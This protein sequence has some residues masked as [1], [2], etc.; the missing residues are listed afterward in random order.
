MKI[1]IGGLENVILK[2]ATI[3]STLKCPTFSSMSF[4]IN[5]IVKISIEPASY[6]EVTKLSEALETLVLADPNLG[7][8]IE[9]SGLY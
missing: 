7:Y 6:K 8:K 2:S 5:P 9:D 3:S 4:H 1:A